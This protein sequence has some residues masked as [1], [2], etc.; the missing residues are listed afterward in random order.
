MPDSRHSVPDGPA[1]GARGQP[2]SPRVPPARAQSPWVRPRMGERVDEIAVGVLCQALQGHRAAGGIADQ[3]FQLVAPRGGDLGIGVER[4]ALH[5]DR[6]HSPAAACRG[7]GCRTTNSHKIHA[8]HRRVSLA[9]Q[10][11]RQ[12]RRERSPDGRQR[13]DRA[14]WCSDHVAHRRVVQPPDVASGWSLCML[15]VIHRYDNVIYLLVCAL[16]KTVEI[17]A[18]AC[19]KLHQS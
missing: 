10:D 6:C 9:R 15:K 4:K 8:A 7:Q 17:F 16:Y 19:W 18:R 3:A 2:A 1:A 11:R 14:R 5:A 12:G 13:R